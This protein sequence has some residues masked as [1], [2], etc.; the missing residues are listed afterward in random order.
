MSAPSVCKST[1]V[2][3]LLLLV[4][5]ALLF[6]YGLDAGELYQTE[7]LRAI[8]AAQFLRSGNWVV[9]TLYGEPLLT[10]PPGMYA[11]IALASWPAGQVSAVTARLPSALAATLTVLCV[12]AG[13]TR[14]LGHRAGLV[15]AAVLP[16]SA[17]WLN[18]V[19]SAEIDLVQLAWV[20]AALWCGLRAVEVRETSASSVGLFCREWPWWQLAL[21][22]VAGGVLTKWTAPAF[23]YLTL[24]PLLW[25]RH[26]LRALWQPAHL[27]SVGLAV[28]PCLVWVSLVVSATSWET[29]FETVRN[30]ALRRL[31][32]LH[33]PRPYPWHEVAT[34]PLRFLAANL[35][36]SAV[37]LFS[38]RP[39]FLALWEE[40]GRRL[41]QLLHCWTW[42]NLAF[43]SLAPGHHIRD[44]L[45]LQPGLAGLAA[46]VWIAWLDGRLAWPF[47][48]CRPGRVLL[49][50]LI[51]WLGCKIV[52]VQVVVP[53]RDSGREPRAKAEQVAAVVPPAETLYLFQVKDEGIL[54]YYGRPARR[55]SHP[56]LMPFTQQGVYCLIR[57][58]EW[59]LLPP[60]RRTEVL[61]RLS[62]EQGDPLLLVKMM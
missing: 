1:P 40:P 10:K 58:A 35:P 46:L 31:S 8:I 22:C 5:C 11:A 32:P 60:E 44:G 20:T 53:R 2:V 57:P 3:L 27:L 37:A 29:L 52:F 13:F 14:R 41:A 30:E 55:L 50:L 28:V 51:L 59:K 18:R 48:R 62:D 38:L 6:F 49:T 25:W 7:S 16:A 19:P 43:W 47:P 15:A 36:W 21:L 54:F 9:P 12:Y 39:G 23:F 56:G 33:H 24:V 26:G 61:L 45:P 17:L 34:Y 4:F 42:S